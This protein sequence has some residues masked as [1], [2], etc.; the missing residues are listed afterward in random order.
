MHLLNFLTF[1]HQ[2]LDKGTHSCPAPA[3]AMTSLSSST[4][5]DQER[6]YIESYINQ[7]L[8][9]KIY[10]RWP[11]MFTSLTFCLL[12]NMHLLN[13]LTFTH[14]N[15]DK[16]THS[17]PAPAMAMTSLSSSIARGQERQYIASCINPY[18]EIKIYF[19]FLHIYQFNFLPV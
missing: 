7:Y 1:T 8:E 10:V 9:I 16:R 2:N 17:C 12:G 11:L 14:Q 5:R 4:A 6:Q 15:Q 19:R 18:S 13:F 3:I